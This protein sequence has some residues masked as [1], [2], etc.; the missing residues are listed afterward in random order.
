MTIIKGGP[1]GNTNAINAS[2]IITTTTCAHTSVQIELF[3]QPKMNVAQL[4]TN[5]P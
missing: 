5:P 1:R 3:P 4:M 2:V